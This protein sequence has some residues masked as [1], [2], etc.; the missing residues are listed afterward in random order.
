MHFILQWN[1]R[2]LKPNY[3]DLQ[4]LVRW[5]NPFL[6]CLQETKLSPT[7]ACSIK[8]YAVYREDV[9]SITIAHGGAFVAVHHSVPTHQLVLRSS[10]QAVAVRVYMANRELTSC[11]IYLPPGIPLPVAEL[12][13]LLLELPAPVLVVGDFNLHNTAWGRTYTGTRG[14]LLQALAGTGGDATPPPPGFSEISFCLP[15]ECHHF[16]IAF[17]PSFLRPPENFKTVTPLTFDL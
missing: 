17:R 4:T 7:T 11:S 15:F 3:Q 12:R 16:S 10:L 6:I 1:C 14:H 8:G 2:G 5:R 13:Q 9:H